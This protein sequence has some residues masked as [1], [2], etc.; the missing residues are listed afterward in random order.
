M[1]EREKNRVK[2]KERESR[3]VKEWT[4]GKK[5]NP[6]TSRVKKDDAKELGICPEDR[7]RG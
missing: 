6:G 7:E 2:E 3:Q 5:T 1:I 4:A